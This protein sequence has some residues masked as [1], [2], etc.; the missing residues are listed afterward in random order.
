MSLLLRRPPGREAYPGDVFYLHSRLLERSAQMSAYHGGGSLTALPVI[1]TLGGDMAAYIPTNVISITDGQIF[2]ETELFN[3]GVRPAIHVGLSVSRIGSAAQ[4]RLMKEVVKTL[5]LELAQYRDVAALAEFGSDL[6]APTLRLLTRGARL[7]ELLKQDQ[8]K[9]LSFSMQ[10]MLLLFGMRGCFDSVSL[11][12]VSQ[13]KDRLIDFFSNITYL[14]DADASSYAFVGKLMSK[15]DH[16]ISKGTISLVDSG[17][18]DIIP[19]IVKQERDM[20]VSYTNRGL[21][22]RSGSYKSLYPKASLT[23]ASQEVYSLNYKLFFFHFLKRIAVLGIREPTVLSDLMKMDF[24]KNINASVVNYLSI[25][26]K[27]I[28]FS[29]GVDS[30]AFLRI[31]NRRFIPRTVNFEDFKSMLHRR[32]AVSIS[33]EVDVD[34]SF[35]DYVP[36]L[37]D[38][39]GVSA[40]EYFISG[41][42]KV[43]YALSNPLRVLTRISSDQSITVSGS[44]FRSLYGYDSVLTISSIREIFSRGYDSIASFKLMQLGHSKA[45]VLISMSYNNMASLGK[46]QHALLKTI[47]A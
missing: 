8:Y 27:H 31:L 11:G 23:E 19:L 37:R 35:V 12:A 21:W 47:L 36:S 4:I 18:I 26:S 2:L 7:V 9:P 25:F 5:K 28:Y 6:D 38:S 29:K 39:T 24:W 17:L 32:Y 13:Y 16:L 3:K 42:D 41:N 43:K 45:K 30:Y 22:F 34:S 20:Y 1:E 40:L 15:I 33:S 44:V 10:I 14:M 46:N